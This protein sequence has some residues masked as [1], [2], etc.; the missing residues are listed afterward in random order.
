MKTMCCG[1]CNAPFVDPKSLALHETRCQARPEPP[2]S[3][4]G[5]A[6]LVERLLIANLKLWEICKKKASSA[7][8]PDAELR[9]LVQD[10]LDLCKSRAAI[11]AEINARLGCERSG[12]SVKHY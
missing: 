8:V 11:R 2:P 9:K 6:E 5:V 1:Y 4:E 7:T 12:E 3:S 10:D